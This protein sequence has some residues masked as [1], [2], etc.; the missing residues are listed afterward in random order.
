MTEVTNESWCKTECHA[1]HMGVVVCS[2]SNGH[3]G[4]HHACGV[5]ADVIWT[6]EIDELAEAGRRKRREERTT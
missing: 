4:H 3:P 2:K 1:G 5:K 6:D